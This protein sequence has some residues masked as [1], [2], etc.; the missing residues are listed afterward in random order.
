MKATGIVRR[1]DDLGRVVIPKELCRVNG[2]HPGTP[3]EFFTG[4][5]GEIIIRR[6]AYEGKAVEAAKLI[7]DL[8]TELPPEKAKYIRELADEIVSSLTKED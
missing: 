2:I 4:D 5:N 7:A 3:M 8:T 1:M 6:F